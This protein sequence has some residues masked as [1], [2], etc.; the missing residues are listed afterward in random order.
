LLNN[1][2]SVCGSAIPSTAALL[3]PAVLEPAL[4]SLALRQCLPRDQVHTD[5]H[6]P[7]R[8]AEAIGLRRVV[9]IEQWLTT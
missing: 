9:T 3:R 1:R 4:H 7:I 2:L 8:R 5:N 6:A